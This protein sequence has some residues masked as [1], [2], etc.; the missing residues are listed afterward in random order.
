V[1]SKIH[2]IQGTTKKIISLS[3]TPE[4]FCE[5]RWKSATE[6]ITYFSFFHLPFR[7]SYL[8]KKYI[9]FF[10][11]FFLLGQQEG[12]KNCVIANHWGDSFPSLSPQSHFI[13]IINNFSKPSN[14][15]AR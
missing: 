12:E 4:I 9:H 5:M 13:V 10:S 1:S 8:N 14:H 15:L 11:R 3:K 2:I 6:S 7:S